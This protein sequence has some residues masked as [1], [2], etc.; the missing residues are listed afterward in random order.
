[1]NLKQY[2]I[3]KTMNVISVYIKG[4]KR[5]TTIIETLK[6]TNKFYLFDYKKSYLSTNIFVVSVWQTFNIM[7]IQC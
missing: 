5:K 6:K 3:I 7:E 1:L 2:N 4:R